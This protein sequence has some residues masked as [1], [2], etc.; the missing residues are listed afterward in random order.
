[1]A[2]K[3][4][5]SRNTLTPQTAS[6]RMHTVHQTRCFK[7]K[8]LAAADVTAIKKEASWVINE[9]QKRERDGVKFHHASPPPLHRVH[10]PIFPLLKVESSWTV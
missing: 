1:M 4:R 10:L 2:H 3:I 9:E 7:S 8:G 6:Q 5:P